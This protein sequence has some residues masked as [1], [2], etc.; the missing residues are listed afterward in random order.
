MN[1][2]SITIRA[3]ANLDNQSVTVSLSCRIGD[4]PN[5]ETRNSKS[6]C[7]PS[8]CCQKP[9]AGAACREMSRTF[10]C[11]TGCT[12]VLEAGRKSD[13]RGCDSEV[14]FLGD[15]PVVGELF[16]CKSCA[17]RCNRLLVLVTPTVCGDG[18]GEESSTDS[19]ANPAVDV[20][21]FA[22]PVMCGDWQPVASPP[23]VTQ[24]MA[25]PPVAVARCLPPAPPMAMEF[26]PVMPRVVA[27]QPLP[28]PVP[29]AMVRPAACP[30]PG[31]PS[32]PDAELVNLMIEYYEACAA[33]ENIKA[34]NLAA[35]CIAIDPTCFA[36]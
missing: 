19:A 20:P 9:C 32:S 1:G 26:L 25:G 2:C 5:S 13:D 24:W 10:A 30:A 15:L 34:R 28:T 35:R 7:C 8:G 36:R 18:D 11:P 27:G 23:A 6:D 3:M 22:M 14:P 21:L 31:V 29:Q 4:N 17:A 12:V 33:G 16:R